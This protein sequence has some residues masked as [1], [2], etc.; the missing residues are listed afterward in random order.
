MALAQHYSPARWRMTRP[1]KYWTRPWNA[2][3][4][5]WTCTACGARCS[6]KDGDRGRALEAYGELLAEIEGDWAR[7]QCGQCG[8]VS[9]QLTWKCP[10]CHQWDSMLPRAR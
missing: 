1:W 6:C 4:T 3:P 8:F 9:H 10:R 7:Y 5:C 2:P